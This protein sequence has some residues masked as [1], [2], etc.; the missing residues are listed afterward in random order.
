MV[1]KLVTPRTKKQPP[2]GGSVGSLIL[3][4]LAFLYVW[5]LPILRPRGDY[6]W[7]HYRLIDLYLGV[8]L[9]L[10][11][12]G[13]TLVAL[14]PERVRRPLALRLLS[15]GIALGLSALLFDLTYVL[16][17]RK[18]GQANYWL[19]T[20]GLLRSANR[21]DPELGY[22]RKAHLQWSGYAL[23]SARPMEYRTDEHGFRNASSAGPVDVVFLG[24]SFT[25]GDG[26]REEQTFVQLVG[27]ATKLSVRNLG[28]GG[29]GPPQQ[30]L[31]LQRHGLPAR[32]RAIVWQ[33]FEGNDLAD[34]E[35]F[36]L[37]RKNPDQPVPSMGERYLTHSLFRRVLN[38]TVRSAAAS[39]QAPGQLSTPDGQVLPLSSRDLKPYHPTLPAMIPLGMA[40]TQR[41]IA[42]GYRACRSRCVPLLVVFVPLEVRVL[43]PFILFSGPNERDRALPAGLTT[44]STDFASTLGR[45]CRQLGCSFLD[46]YPR[47]SERAHQNWQKLYILGDGHL[48]TAGHQLVADEVVRWLRSEQVVGTAR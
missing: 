43:K 46:L 45:F 10:L 14:S 38:K 22:A 26:V 16:G 44:A 7:G 3:L 2:I 20:V 47:L 23:D 31:V 36:A 33:I 42:A 28:V 12:L 27:A 15:V 41:S 35:R 30:L 24:D 9:A 6:G 4:W 8:P 25:E 21:P 32:P 11:T 40:E 5:V 48:D 17:V 29:Y 1:D 19:D 13:A 39:S 37:W 18:I 34:A